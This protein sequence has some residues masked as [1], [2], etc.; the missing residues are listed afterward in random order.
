MRLYAVDNDITKDLNHRSADFNKYLHELIC[1]KVETDFLNPTRNWLFTF[2]AHTTRE[3]TGSR[4][5]SILEGTVTFKMSPFLRRKSVNIPKPLE[6][7]S[8][9]WLNF[10]INSICPDFSLVHFR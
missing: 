3:K 7:I 2:F 10:S 1:R 6:L 9:P 8:I 4:A 5:S